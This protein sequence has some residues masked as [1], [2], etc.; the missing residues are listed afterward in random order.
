MSIE[1]VNCVQGKVKKNGSRIENFP[2]FQV[3]LC[4]FSFVAS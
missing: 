1:Q 3:G 2:Y 4:I